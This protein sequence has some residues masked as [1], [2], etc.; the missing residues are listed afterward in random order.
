MKKIEAVFLPSK[1][2]EVRDAMSKH[3]VYRFLVSDTTIHAY[4]SPS[5]QWGT[6]STD[7]ESTTLKLE[8]VVP[9][10]I[11]ASLAREILEVA[12]TRHPTVTA[13]ISPVD[14]QMEMAIGHELSASKSR[15][16]TAKRS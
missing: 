7:D 14:D 3:G 13:T 9:D 15:R 11:A 16:G 12:R 2:D 4:E 8:A 10:E 5:S 1:L 6:L